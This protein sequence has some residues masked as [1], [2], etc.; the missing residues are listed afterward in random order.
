[1]IDY[2]REEDIPERQLKNC[3]RYSLMHTSYSKSSDTNK[4]AIASYNCCGGSAQVKVAKFDLEVDGVTVQRNI[5]LSCFM[6]LNTK[7]AG[8]DNYFSP[9]SMI[10]DGMIEAVYHLQSPNSS[11]FSDTVHRASKLGGL[12]TYYGDYSTYRG[13]TMKVYNRNAV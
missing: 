4:K 6:V 5:N 8:G 1:M 11:S 12:Q 9:H 13:A 7:I 2:E 3:L 10:N